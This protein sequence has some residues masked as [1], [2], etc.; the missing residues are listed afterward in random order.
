MKVQDFSIEIAEI[1]L[2]CTL[3]ERV[4]YFERGSPMCLVVAIRFLLIYSFSVESHLHILLHLL[5]LVSQLTESINDQ[6]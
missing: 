3:I 5:L 2:P 1:Q 6:T 4:L